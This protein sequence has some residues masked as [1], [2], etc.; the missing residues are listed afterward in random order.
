M[1]LQCTFPDSEGV[2]MANF[3]FQFEYQVS[4][5]RFVSEQA[6]SPSLLLEELPDPDLGLGEC[7]ES[8][9]QRGAMEAALKPKLTLQQGQEVPVHYN[10]KQ[11]SDAVI[12][13]GLIAGTDL[14]YGGYIVAFA[15]LILGICGI[16]MLF[17]GVHRLRK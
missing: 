14:T 1:A 10:P 15:P 8:Q 2:R 13:P 7:P 4:G 3:N 9:S 5:T 6:I 12:K 11:P 17:E 16:V